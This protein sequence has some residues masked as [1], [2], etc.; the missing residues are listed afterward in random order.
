MRRVPKTVRR[1][2]KSYYICTKNNSVMA[3]DQV[4]VDNYEA[5]QEKEMSFLD[6]LE[7]LRWHLVRSVVAILVVATVVFLA[8]DFVFNT[9]IFGPKSENFFFYQG[10]CSFSDLIGMGESLCMKPPEFAIIAVEFGERFIVHLKVSAI[11]GFVVAFPYIFYQFWSFIAPGLYEEERQAAR[12]VV[13]IC[14]A[15]FM[16]GVLFGYF[17]ISPFAVSFLAGYEIQ[18]VASTTTLSSFVGYMT[19]FTLPTG[20][21]FELPVVVYFLAKVGLITAD[22]MRTYRRH[23]FIVIL[24][25]AALITPPDV[26]TQFLIGFPLYILYEISIIIAGRVEK[27][28]ELAMR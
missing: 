14:S 21:V 24:I 20:M 18:D 17:I 6:H 15:L 8:K 7:E 27:K 4:D 2:T 12:G 23:A 26:V 10:I 3:L 13:F 9:V 19:M 25:L 5:Q 22:F 1:F 28:N 16:L 11:L